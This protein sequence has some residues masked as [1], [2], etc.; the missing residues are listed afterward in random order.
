MALPQNI[1]ENLPTK[2][3]EEKEY[4]LDFPA[5]NF[6]VRIHFTTHKSYIL[7]TYVRDSTNHAIIKESLSS[8]EVDSYDKLDELFDKHFRWRLA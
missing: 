3:G 6:F 8:G 1:K 5:T 2:M 7:S 4:A